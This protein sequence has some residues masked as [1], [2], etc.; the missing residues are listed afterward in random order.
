MCSQKVAVK[1][2]QCYRIDLGGASNRHV[3]TES[4]CETSPF[5]YK[6]PIPDALQESC[7]QGVAVEPAHRRTACS[8]FTV[9]AGMCSQR[10]AVKL[11]SRYCCITNCLV[12]GMCSQRVAVKPL[13]AGCTVTAAC[14]SRNVFTESCSGTANWR[15]LN[16]SRG[17]CYKHGGFADSQ[18]AGNWSGVPVPMPIL[19][20][21][22]Q[23]SSVSINS[24]TSGFSGSG[25]WWNIKIFVLPRYSLTQTSQVSKRYNC[26]HS[27]TE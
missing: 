17:E 2:P 9:V 22:T 25:A 27:P 16:V 13:A 20:S 12:A 1:P 4:C 14:R 7:S 15:R 6:Q 26:T 23:S 19:H 11:L 18:P 5:C 8:C 24:L 10:V 21:I 3:F